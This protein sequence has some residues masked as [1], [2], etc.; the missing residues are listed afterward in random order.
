MIGIG[1]DLIWTDYPRVQEL[2]FFAGMGALV[3]TCLWHVWVLR[4]RWR[5]R[6]VFTVNVLLALYLTFLWINTGIYQFYF[7]NYPPSQ[8]ALGS[9]FVR[10]SWDWLGMVHIIVGLGHILLMFWTMWWNNRGFIGARVSPE[11]D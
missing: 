3:A 11:E 9:A 2:Y 4:D 10:R 8:D 1:A 5:V 6:G 7:V